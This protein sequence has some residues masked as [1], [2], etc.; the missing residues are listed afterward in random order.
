MHDLRGKSADTHPVLKAGP[1]GSEAF[2]VLLVILVLVALLSVPLSGGHLANLLDVKVRGLPILI[3][4]LVVQVLVISVIPGASEHLDTAL[5]LLTYLVALGFVAM[6]L[7]LRGMWI[8]GLGGLLN[9]VAI[10]ANGGVMPANA[11]ALRAAGRRVTT[12]TF[13]NS[14][15]VRHARVAF[16]GDVFAM[17]ASWPMANVFSIGDV[18]IA[19]GVAVVVHQVCAS[20]LTA[21]GRHDRPAVPRA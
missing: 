5:H 2:L 7:R 8:I 20:R 4:A 14:T 15:A 18:L 19:V 9:F 16:L 17:P 6:N 1:D 13:E 11:D 10:A 21:A 3:G 12:S